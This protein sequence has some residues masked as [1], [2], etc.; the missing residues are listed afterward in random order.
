[1]RDAGFRQ[2]RTGAAAAAIA[3]ASFLA[4]SAGA[5]TATPWRHGLISAH[6]DAGFFYMVQNGFAEK[7]GL[8]LEIVQFKTDI[9]AL[10]SLIAGDLDSFE[11][12]PAS[13][14]VAAARG[15]DIKIIGCNWQALP[16]V[17]YARATVGSLADLKGKTLA[18][19]A[20]AGFPAV[21]ARGIL[22]KNGVPPATVNFANLGADVERYK[23]VLAGVADAAIVS[24]EYEPI[25]EKQGL[26]SLIASKDAFP[27]YIRQCAM[28]SGKALATRRDAA[29][30]F[31][32]AEMT[33]LHYA[34]SH[35]DEALRLA[36][37]MTGLKADD[38]RP[39]FVYDQ[40]LRSHAID[41][42]WPIPMAKLRW[43]E[44]QLVQEGSIKQGFDPALVVDTGVRASALE[45]LGTK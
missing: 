42:A 32:M 4:P 34:L 3:L 22:E 19:S 11:G 25:V 8:K 7:Q 43:M 31:M 36:R 23:A 45:F 15:G 17:I 29:V 13:S 1:M 33:A 35:R 14:M 41:P 27:D 44:E 26:K 37:E 12:G 40:A 28:T 5:E 18:I 38:P 24:D 20:P 10:Q 21:I 2:L 39:E 16:Y 6:S 9:T 30:R